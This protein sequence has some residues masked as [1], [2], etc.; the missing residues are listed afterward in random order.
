MRKKLEPDTASLAAGAPATAA[1]D[2]PAGYNKGDVATLTINDPNR[3]LLDNI[4]VPVVGSTLTVPLTV[5]IGQ[6][7]PAGTSHVF[8][9]KSD[10]P[11]TG[12]SVWTT[13]A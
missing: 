10:N 2:K 7:T 3:V 5:L 13:T 4:P 11:A 8:T 1:F 6:V 12:T 9:L